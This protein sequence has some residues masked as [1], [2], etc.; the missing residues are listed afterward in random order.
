[1]RARQDQGSPVA[2]DGGKDPGAMAGG[3][4]GAHIGVRVGGE[5]PKG[6]DHSSLKPSWRVE[7][8]GMSLEP[9]TFLLPLPPLDI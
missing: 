5:K 7:E 9:Q 3:S 8:E 1:M 4:G 6:K 2:R